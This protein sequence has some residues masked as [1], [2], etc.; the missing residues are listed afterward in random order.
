M[1]T[2]KINIILLI[3]TMPC[4]VYSQTDEINCLKIFNTL[5]YE[6]LL[7][8][9]DCK[10]NKVSINNIDIIFEV[11]VSE[12]GKLDSVFI[13]KSNLNLFL[14]NE[15]SLVSSIVGKEIPCLR[16]VYYKNQLIPDKIIISFNKKLVEYK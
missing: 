14:I 1:K 11:Y 12:Y 16:K 9:V 7:N 3:I 4:F 15:E 10:K 6:N 8:L 5:V 13:K 2:I